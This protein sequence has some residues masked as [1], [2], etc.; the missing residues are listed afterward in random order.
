[1]VTDTSEKAFQNHI[2][3][4]LTCTGY[5]RRDTSNFDKTSCLDL[6]L[7]LNFILE[8][9]EKEWK[10]YQK[11]YGSNAESKFLFRLVNEIRN[12]G[13]INVL[14]NGFKD[15]GCKFEL[16]YPRP[17]NKKNPDLF[18]KY[19]KNIFSVVDELEYQEREMGNRLD[20]AIFINGMPILTIELKDTFSQGVE[21]AI[22]QY[23][24][25]RDPR[26]TIFKNC[27]VHFAMSDEKIFMATKLS[28]RS[29][30]FLP[31]NRGLDNPE[32]RN[33]YKT[34][35]LYTEILQINN[36]SKLISNFVYMEKKEGKDYPIFPRYHQLDCV[37]K[38]MEDALP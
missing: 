22:K 16:F 27:F 37:N 32:V 28:G 2:I 8:T 11:V 26:E 3:S 6:A 35:Y 29:T 9:Q 14:R 12:K 15:T 24:E 4:H 34:S 31:F 7:T 5:R 13:T 20:L 19:E 30:R 33:D 1:M 10:K 17:N 25:D 23:R 21:K 18:D 38:L 36:L